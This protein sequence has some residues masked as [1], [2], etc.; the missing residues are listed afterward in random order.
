LETKSP[1]DAQTYKARLEPTLTEIRVLLVRKTQP[2]KR[3]P[4][5]P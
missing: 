2:L 5:F 1:N 4:S 3:L